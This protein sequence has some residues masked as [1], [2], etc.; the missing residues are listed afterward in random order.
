[1][2][3]KITNLFRKVFYENEVIFYEKKNC[4]NSIIMIQLNVNVII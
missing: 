3:K 4:Y 2:T 1:M